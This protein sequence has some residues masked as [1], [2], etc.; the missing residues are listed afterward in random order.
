MK[1]KYILSIFLFVCGLFLVSLVKNETREVQKDIDILKSAIETIR[2]ELHQSTLDFNIITT[3]EN[4]QK[5]VKNNLDTNFI[6]YKRSQIK[7]TILA[8]DLN[9]GLVHVYKEDKNNK[10]INYKLL[11]DQSKEETLYAAPKDSSENKNKK[12]KTWALT[13]VFKSIVGL[14]TLPGK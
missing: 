2:S 12:L 6:S 3:P 9:V 7:E 1:K 13:Q 8:E 11:V 5:L 4:L 14:P 10:K